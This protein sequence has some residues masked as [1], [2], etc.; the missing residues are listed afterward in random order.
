MLYFLSKFFIKTEVCFIGKRI[1]LYSFCF[2]WVGLEYEKKAEMRLTPPGN[3]VEVLIKFLS[4]VCVTIL[5]ICPA[6]YVGQMNA[7]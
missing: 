1:C 3:F 2:E 6:I 5:A 4:G 7:N